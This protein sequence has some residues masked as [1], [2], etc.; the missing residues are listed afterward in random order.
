MEHLYEALEPER[1]EELLNSISEKLNE[2][3][4]ALFFEWAMHSK[5]LFNNISE[6]VAILYKECNI[7]PQS[8]EGIDAFKTLADMANLNEDR[9]MLDSIG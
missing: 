3:E 2:D 8:E 4:M 1:S 9:K 6:K 5:E 7:V